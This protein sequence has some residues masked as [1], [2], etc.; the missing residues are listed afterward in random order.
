MSFYCF[1]NNND[2]FFMMPLYKY[3]VNSIFGRFYKY[4]L[5]NCI[6]VADAGGAVGVVS[7]FIFA[8][9]NTAP[10]YVIDCN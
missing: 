9:A 3:L 7:I 6:V 1:S 4:S 8:V 5:A 2:D 10:Y